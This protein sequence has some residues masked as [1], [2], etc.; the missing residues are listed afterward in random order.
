MIQISVLPGSLF[1]CASGAIQ[2]IL[3]EKSLT[4]FKRT[5]NEI[6]LFNKTQSVPYC[7]AIAKTVNKTV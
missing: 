4:K 7:E 6:V 1:S 5:L 2:I 3:N